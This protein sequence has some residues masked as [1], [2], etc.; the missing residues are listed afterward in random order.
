MRYS[1]SVRRTLVV[2]SLDGVTEGNGAGSGTH[3]RCGLQKELCY[4][5]VCFR[6]EG[7]ANS[8]AF[9]FPFFVSLQLHVLV[10][11]TSSKTKLTL[12]VPNF[13]STKLFTKTFVAV[14]VNEQLGRG[15]RYTRRTVRVQERCLVI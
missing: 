15:G 14:E 8:Y 11:A 1:E 6:I 12:P 13:Y 2:K 5:R 7:N 3:V 4:M 10:V 9:H